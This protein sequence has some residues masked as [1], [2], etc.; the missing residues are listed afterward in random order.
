[1]DN[2]GSYSTGPSLQLKPQSSLPQCLY[3]PTVTHIYGTGRQRFLT[4]K[5]IIKMLCEY[6]W[7]IPTYLFTS[8]S[9]NK[10]W[11]KVSNLFFLDRQLFLTSISPFMQAWSPSPF[12]SPRRGWLL[13][14]KRNLYYYFKKQETTFS[15]IRI[16][17]RIL[18]KDNKT[19]VM[20]HSISTLIFTKEIYF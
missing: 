20:E 2:T 13:R 11:F 3:I 7:S 18:C 1:M 12:F 6:N 17:K 16:N 14:A 9:N 19:K 4:F 5:T 15:Q 10:L 8:W